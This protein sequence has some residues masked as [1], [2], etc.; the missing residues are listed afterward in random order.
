[1]PLIAG[2]LVLVGVALIW[3]ALIAGAVFM[4][5]GRGDC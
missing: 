2:V 1:M 3:V 5:L 4:I